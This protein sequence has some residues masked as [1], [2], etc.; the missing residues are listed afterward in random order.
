MTTKTKTTTK[1]RVQKAKK[2]MKT[3]V[4]KREKT[5]KEFDFS[6]KNPEENQKIVT[7]LKDL[8]IHEG[9]RFM[10]EAFQKNIDFL[11]EQIL[12]K[13]D[14]LSG[15]ELT[16]EEV[17]ELRM[18][19]S[20]LKELLEKPSYFINKLEENPNQGENLDPYD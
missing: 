2:P 17:D 4:I 10:I 8:Q 18:K 1:K 14:A 11:S 9:W 6:F 12:E 5:I 13:E 16:E 15:K 3:V 7:I 19:R 20:Y